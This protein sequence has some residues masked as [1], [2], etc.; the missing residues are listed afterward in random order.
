MRRGIQAVLNFP[1]VEPGRLRSIVL[2]TDGYIGNENEILAEVQRH[3]QPGNRL[4]SFGVGS[5]VNRF[6][7]N[8]I[9]ELGRGISQIIR[10]DEPTTAVAEKFFRQINNPVLTNIQ[11]R[12]EGVGEV[13]IVYPLHPTDLFAEQPLVLFG[14]KGDRQPGQLH[15]T[16]VAAGGDRYQQTFTLDFGAAGNP[17]IAQLWG[18]ARIKDLTNQMVSGDTKAGVEA[19]TDTALT[20]Q[21]LSQ[22]TAFVA[23]SDDVRT[24]PETTGITVAVPVEM[25]EAVSHLGIFG[26]AS[27]ALAAEMIRM[28]RL[29]TSAMSSAS[30]PEPLRAAFSRTEEAIEFQDS[31]VAP[32]N[33]P[34]LS[35]QFF[36]DFDNADVDLTMPM[37]MSAPDP[38]TQSPARPR[39]VAFISGDFGGAP[40][41]QAG[42]APD[43]HR[44][45][46][47]SATGLDAAAI[48][49]LTQHLQTVQPPSGVSGTV[50][51]EFQVSTKRVLGVPTGKP[52]VVQ[53]V[54][55]QQ[56]STL[57]E[58]AVLDVLRRSLIT[59][60]P[61][62]SIVGTVHLVLQIN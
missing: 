46:I 35:D 40:P 38:E 25:P 11:L 31:A 32:S 57:Q 52:C 24:A 10:H 6:L 7:L 53:L 50:V 41:A 56:A 36:D 45:Q 30:A 3:L 4:Y 34:N 5:S 22:Y 42:A 37:P 28:R 8:R 13:P 23:V 47:V 55:D 62:G 58:A 54:L 27:P 14:R 48:A 60:Q 49:H 33:F 61:Q 29:Q 20:Y 21:L 16:G 39:A 18:R 43:H 59:W 19:V 12:W 2:L 26:S 1:I 17:A 44:L 15:V 9:A 51:F